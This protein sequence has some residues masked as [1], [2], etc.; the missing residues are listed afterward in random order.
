VAAAG[1]TIRGALLAPVSAVARR[2]YLDTADLLD[3]GDGRVA[4]D[5]VAALVRAMAETQTMLVVS[6]EHVQDVSR[7]IASAVESFVR[8]VEAF[9]PVLAVMDGPDAIEPLTAERKDIG[10][11]ACTNFRELVYSEAARP[12]LSKVNAAYE[13][14]HA[15][16]IAAQRVSSLAAAPA[17][18]S[19][20]GNELFLKAFIT[21]C[22]GW[23]SDEP[24]VVVSYWAQKAGIEVTPSER[25]GII[26]RLQAAR[27]AMPALKQLADENSMDVTDALQRWGQWAHDPAAWPGHW[28]ALQVA[29]ARTRNVQRSPR[30]S[31]ALDLDHV[32]HFPY[33]DVAT[34]DG[35]TLNGLR[36]AATKVGPRPA[37]II[38]TGSLNGVTEAVR[39][40]PSP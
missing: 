28:L 16:Q 32:K 34:C 40:L 10:L 15:G 3:I 21:L 5:T 20:K 39:T 36:R 23:L 33:V 4:A 24:N 38:K 12:W 17:L 27:A 6:R 26:C 2:L 29:A 9:Q 35:D 37:V 13:Q 1:R 18:R 19:R 7:G 25:E 8:A 31:D 30:L 22:R 14:L 11:V